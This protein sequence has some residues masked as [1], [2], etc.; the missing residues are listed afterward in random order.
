MIRQELQQPATNR[1]TM[2]FKERRTPENSFPCGLFVVIKS[3]Q[4]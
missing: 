3:C 2:P 4:T 1:N